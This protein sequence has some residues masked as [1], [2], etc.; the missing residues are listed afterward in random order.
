MGAGHDD[1][2]PAEG[3]ARGMATDAQRLG[4]RYV[5]GPTALLR[6]G[7]LHLL[8]DPTFDPPGEHPVGD[9]VLHKTAGPA[10]GPQG[11]GAVDA[12]LLSHDQHPD[13]LDT[14][15]RAYLTGVPLVLSTASAQDRLGGNVR[16]LAAW[17][18]VELPRPGR[19]ALQVTGV[20]AQHGPDGSEHL[21]GQV[22][23][24][25]LRGEGLPT[26]YVS[27]DNASLDV[28]GAIADRV[29]PVDVAVL[30]A[31]AAR[32]ALAGGACLTL[33][34]QAAAEAARLLD[35]R[36]VVPLHFEGWAHFTQGRDTLPAAFD[37][38][39][40]A[41]RLRLPEPGGLVELCAPGLPGRRA[42]PREELTT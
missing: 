31:G 27:G 13:N 17:T 7:G 1:T 15:G 2:R 28:V 18:S 9:R 11:L 22:T 3:H 25:V 6:V 21:V 37:R 12:V 24:F 29:G 41:D 32:T 35:A 8:T 33:T 14:L 42:G 16:A 26:V 10:V 19:R 4:I 40:L 5:G 30:F 38:A 20:P 39:G 36:A 34:S 23:G